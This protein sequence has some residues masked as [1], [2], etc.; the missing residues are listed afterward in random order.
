MD[1]QQPQSHDQPVLDLGGQ[2]AGER[3]TAIPEHYHRQLRAELIKDDELRLSKRAVALLEEICDDARCRGIKPESL[4]I[5]L[6]DEIRTA[7]TTD[8]CRRRPLL[9][10]AV[11]RCIRLFFA[12]DTSS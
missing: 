6:K 10:E 8:E 3:D 12:T 1:E 4:I 9:D 2:F 11:T 5:A 7:T